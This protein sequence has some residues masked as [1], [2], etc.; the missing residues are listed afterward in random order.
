MSK[1][2]Q[3]E[4]KNGNFEHRDLQVS[5]I[6]YFLLSLAVATVLAS[7]ILVGVYKFLDKRDRANQSVVSPLVANVPK[8][9]LNTRAEYEQYAE[10]TFPNPRLETDERNQL[11]QIRTRED[12]L[13]DSYGWVDEKAGTVRIPI[14]RAMDLLV[15]RGLPVRPQGASGVMAA[16]T[17]GATD[18]ISDA[19]NGEP[20]VRKKGEKK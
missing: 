7:V 8:P 16:A 9:E 19:R 13:L 20:R 15:E 2:T 4:N 6:L 14:E 3:H 12:D 18:R 10:K 5:G 17:A 1:Q 11:N